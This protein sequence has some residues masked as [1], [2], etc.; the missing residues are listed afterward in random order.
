MRSEKR[1]FLEL[2][3]R[4]LCT[5]SIGDGHLR[6]FDKEESSTLSCFKR[7]R[8]FLGDAAAEKVILLREASGFPELYQQTWGSLSWATGAQTLFCNLSSCEGTV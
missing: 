5:I 1:A 6:V 2:W 8:E 3:A 4:I 7:E